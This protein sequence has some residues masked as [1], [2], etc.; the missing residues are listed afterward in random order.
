[1]KLPSIHLFIYSENATH[2]YEE[3]Y[4]GSK[5]NSTVFNAFSTFIISSNSPVE[6]PFVPVQMS[7]TFFRQKSVLEG[8]REDRG[9]NSTGPTGKDIDSPEQKRTVPDFFMPSRTYRSQW[10]DESMSECQRINGT[11]NSRRLSPGLQ[12]T[13]E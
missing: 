5:S 1:M 9:G 11:P 3:L 10:M 13:M 6:H 7:R 12:M 2:T 8:K 4:H